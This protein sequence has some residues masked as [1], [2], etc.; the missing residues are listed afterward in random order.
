M[1]KNRVSKRMSTEE[2]AREASGADC[3]AGKCVSGASK[4]TGRRAE[5]PALHAFDP[6]S[7]D[8]LCIDLTRWTRAD[9]MVQ[10]NLILGH[11]IIHF[12]KSLGV[13]KW[14]SKLMSAAELAMSEQC[15]RMSEWMNKW[16]ST[17]V[18][19]LGYSEPLCA[20]SPPCNPELQ[21]IDPHLFSHAYSPNSPGNLFYF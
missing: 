15:E 16:P 10:N 11:Q 12:P 7:F 9:T 17:Y 1:A 18:S 8:S 5:S 4:W 20:A 14:A 3:G 21:S 13:N 6:L 19:L 2:Q